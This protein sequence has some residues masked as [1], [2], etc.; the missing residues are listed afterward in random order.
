MFLLKARILE[1]MRAVVYTRLVHSSG[2][3]YSHRYQVALIV[4]SVSDPYSLIPDPIP[5]FR[6]NIDPD[7]GV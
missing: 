5:A 4:P 2:K 3:K 1:V 7:T 6:L